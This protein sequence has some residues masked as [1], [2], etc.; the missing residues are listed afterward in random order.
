MARPDALDPVLADLCTRLRAALQAAGLPDADPD[1][2]RP[3]QPE[4]GEWAT[5]L[6]LRLAKPARLAPREIAQSVLDHLDVPEQVAQVEI[7]GPG[8]INFRLSPAYYAGLVRRV[9]AEQDAFGRQRL[10]DDR[11]ERINVEFVSANPTGPLHVGAGRWAAT[12][13]AI[14]ALLQAAGHDVT[15]EYYVNDAGEQVRRFGESVVLAAGGGEL[16]EDHYRGAYISE[17]AADLREAHGEGIFG[18]DDDGGADAAA[19]VGEL[20]VEAMRS[21]IAAQLHQLGVDFDV[22]FSEASLHERG[23]IDATIAQ[24]TE[25]GRTYVDD[26]AT[27]LTTT[28]F[29]D[30]KDRVLVRSDGRPTYFAA[31]CA[32]LRDKWSRA[33]RLFY[34][35]GADHHGYVARLHAAAQ[36]LGIPADRVEIRIGQLV[37]LL[38]GGQPVRM[39]K[40]AGE[41][42]TLDEVVDEV[43]VDV[44]RYHFL[45]QGLDTQVDFDLAVVTQQSMENPVYY[46]QYAHARISS[47]IRMADERGFDHGAVDDAD[48]TLLEHPAEHELLRA[49]ARLPLEIAEAAELRATQRLARYAEE[50]AGTFHRFYTECRV[51]APDD[52]DRSA[53]EQAALDALGRA[54]YWLAV[55]A[56]QALADALALL[57]VSAPERM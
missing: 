15:R 1:L 31:D 12:G 23:D 25:Q 20:A 51:L 18:S 39:S 38:R 14:A 7:A 57:R 6:A 21:R 9:V 40:R 32:Y 17:I 29:G 22:W 19:R 37:N 28:E 35:L 42:I 48:L 41:L 26:G 49:M 46:V 33:D 2:E 11:R 16:T 30:D 8:F 10:D 54:R 34:L 4:H 44:T 55:A 47:L 24:L 50:L 45:R 43:G 5:T 27:F 53:E 13:D 56:R 36:C 3:R 52:D